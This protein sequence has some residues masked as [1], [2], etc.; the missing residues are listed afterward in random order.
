MEIPSTTAGWPLT[1]AA[2][3]GGSVGPCATSPNAL[4]GTPRS[5]SYGS[6]PGTVATAEIREVVNGS[7]A[8][9]SPPDI[10]G[11]GYVVKSMEAALWA[12]AHNDSYASATLAAANLAMDADTTAAICGMLA[13]AHWGESG[14][15]T[16]WLDIIA[17]RRDIE[18]LAEEL[19]RQSW[20][21]WEL[22]V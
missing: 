8:T 9:K 11:S 10:V 6:Y 22:G 15:P 14:I 20:A 1:T 18:W 17:R 5:V 4:S 12:F 13:G 16:E 3:T 7:Y 2:V 21:G 19:L